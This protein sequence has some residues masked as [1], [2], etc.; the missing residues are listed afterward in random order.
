LFF[1]LLLYHTHFHFQAN[2]D[3][4]TVVLPRKGVNDTT[5]KRKYWEICKKWEEITGLALEYVAYDKMIIR[6]VN[7]YISITDKGKIKYKGAFKPHAEMLKDNEYYKAFNQGIVPIALSDYFL[8]NISVED[9]IKNHKNI[10]DFCKTFSAKGKFTCET[11]KIDENGNEYDIKEEQKTIRYYVSKNGVRFRKRGE[12]LK[13]KYIPLNIFNARVKYDEKNIYEN[14]KE[15][16]NL[17]TSEINNKVEEL[18]ESNIILNR[19]EVKVIINCPIDYYRIFSY[20]SPI[21]NSIFEL[22][23]VELNR[24]DELGIFCEKDW[25]LMDIEASGNITIFNEYKELP[26][27]EYDIDYD[28]YIEE[29]NKIID[30]I[31]GKK[32]RL[33]M[34]VKQTKEME[35]QQREERNYIQFCINKIPTERQYNEYKRDWLIEKFGEPKEIKPSKLKNE[36]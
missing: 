10:Y 13:P 31:T 30:T 20:N 17:I 2:T 25:R 8:K 1:V 12:P 16:F 27:E 18:M 22:S 28:Y 35:K 34:E 36:E 5:S 26:F 9:T 3:G 29:C 4:I 19:S 6:D 14:N 21:L 11:Y 33:L 32:E 23:S 24:S 15:K 7:N